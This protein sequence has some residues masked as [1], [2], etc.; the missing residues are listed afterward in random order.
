MNY[1]YWIEFLDKLICYRQT[2]NKLEYSLFVVLSSIEHIA[3]IRALS[4]V[5]FVIGDQL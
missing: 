1:P 4:I 5:K 2:E 3:V